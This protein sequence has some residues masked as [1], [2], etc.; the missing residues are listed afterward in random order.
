MGIRDWPQICYWMNLGGLWRAQPVRLC[1]LEK[2][3]Q[4]LAQAT[5]TTQILRTQVALHEQQLAPPPSPLAA[6]ADAD[7]DDSGSTSDDTAIG[8]NVLDIP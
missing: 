5:Q 6:I 1:Q 3:H 2:F 8:Y 4:E 7:S